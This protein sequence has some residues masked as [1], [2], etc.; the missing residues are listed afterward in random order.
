MDQ[1]T[2]K[3]AIRMIESD[4]GSEIQ[5][6]FQHIATAASYPMFSF[7]IQPGKYKGRG[8]TRHFVKNDRFPEGVNIAFP[9]WFVFIVGLPIIVT[10]VGGIDKLL[11]GIGLSQ[12]E[13][14][15]ME[16]VDRKAASW[17]WMFLP[18]GLA[19]SLPGAPGK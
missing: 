14:T 6:M 7:K 16:E 11:S 8:A 5:G 12:K 18:G 15:A 9:A 10:A 4:Q 1:E 13:E 17:D 2:D 3:G 19:R